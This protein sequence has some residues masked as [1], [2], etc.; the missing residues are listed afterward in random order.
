MANASSNVSSN[1]IKAIF[2]TSYSTLVSVL[3]VLAIVRLI[4]GFEADPQAWLP[5]LGL[6]LA[7]APMAGFF[8]RLFLTMAVA[9]TSPNLA[10]YQVVTV[11]G[12]LLCVGAS[13]WSGSMAALPWAILAAASLYAYVF[14]YS[15][16]EGRSDTPLKG[17]GALPS[18]ALQTTD[19]ASVD[20]ANLRGAPHLLLFYRGNWCPLCQAQIKE[21]AAQYR[22]LAQRGVKVMLISP[23]PAGNSAKLAKRFDAPMDFLVDTDNTAAKALGIFAENGLPATL[24]VLGYDSDVPMPTVIITDAEGIVRWL[25]LTDN[26]RVRPEPETFLRVLDSLP[27]AT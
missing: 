14:W 15:R 26:Y 16:F 11:L 12:A 7:A 5:W 18:F 10:G 4:G 23:Q 3:T 1:L 6:L 24:Q 21:I 19:G 17:G 2:V 13:V 20:S 27:A 22:E 8:A 25:D 9:R